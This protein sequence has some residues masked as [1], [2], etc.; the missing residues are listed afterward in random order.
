MHIDCA[1]NTGSENTCRLLRW[2]DYLELMYTNLSLKPLRGTKVAVTGV[3]F[4]DVRGPSTPV[5]KIQTVE[6]AP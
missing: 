3:E 6:L 4:M 2:L 1:D 5:I